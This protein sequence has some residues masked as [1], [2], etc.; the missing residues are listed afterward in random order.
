[1]DAPDYFDFLDDS[2]LPDFTPTAFRRRFKKVD[3]RH[4][5]LP[6]AEHGPPATKHKMPNK[7]P[8]FK[9]GDIVMNIHTNRAGIITQQT[10]YDPTT[11]APIKGLTIQLEPDLL[12]INQNE[13]DYELIDSSNTTHKER[14]TA[15]KISPRGLDRWLN[16]DAT[17][18]YTICA[19]EAILNVEF[20]ENSDVFNLDDALYYLATHINNF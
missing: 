14:F 10:I 1:M 17:A 5:E 16:Q 15:F 7:Q 20:D 4:I 2:H 13:D 8:K 6:G 9:A 3:T 11:E 19:I 12:S 18:A